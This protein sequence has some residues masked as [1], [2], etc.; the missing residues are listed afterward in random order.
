[1]DTVAIDKVLW[2][3]VSRERER[4]SRSYYSNGVGTSKLMRHNLLIV[5]F[6]PG[7]SAECMHILCMHISCNL[8]ILKRDHM[9]QSKLQT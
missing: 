6:H 3:P 1:M 5:H 8:S 7:P 9:Y 2:L 4:N